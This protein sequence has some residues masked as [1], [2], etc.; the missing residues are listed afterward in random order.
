MG[1]DANPE[2]VGF[3]KALW[4]AVTLRGEGSSYKMMGSLIAGGVGL[5]YIKDALSDLAAGKT[6][7]NPI[8]DHYGDAMKRAF[9]FQSFGLLSDFVLGAGSKPKRT[10]GRRW[11]LCRDRK[12]RRWATSLT[13]CRRADPSLEAEERRQLFQR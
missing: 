4:R 11:A 13:T 10:F 9:V 6:P 7:E 12:Q 8:G 3:A 1:Q 2:N 5:G